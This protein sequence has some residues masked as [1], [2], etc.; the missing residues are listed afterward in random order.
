MEA[1][2]IFFKKNQKSEQRFFENFV[3]YI[4]THESDD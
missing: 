2:S 4:L 1:L 3:L